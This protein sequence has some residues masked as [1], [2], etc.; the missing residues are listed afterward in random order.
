MEI[1]WPGLEVGRSRP[2]AVTV[3]TMTGGASVCE[4]I[5]GFSPR[6]IRDHNLHWIV[7]NPD[8]L[9]IGS[10]RRDEANLQGKSDSREAG[11]PK[12]TVRTTTNLSSRPHIALG[13]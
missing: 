7:S 4:N 12:A 2:V 11:W 1:N 10:T 6:I 9:S 3:G 13:N 5:A 8:D